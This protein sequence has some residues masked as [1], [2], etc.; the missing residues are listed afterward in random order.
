[1]QTKNH[2]YVLS[3]I[4]WIVSERDWSAGVAF[5][6]IDDNP[7]TVQVTEHTEQ[8]NAR[9]TR[10]IPIAGNGTAKI[11]VHQETRILYVEHPNTVLITAHQF[12]AHGVTQLEV[13]E[14][15]DLKK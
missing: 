8:G 1:M 2:R 6:N 15:T 13:H 12:G 14:V 5:T 7:A 3:V 10:A 9:N 4:P 11:A